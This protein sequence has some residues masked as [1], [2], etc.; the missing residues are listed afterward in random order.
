MSI[1]AGMIWVVDKEN[2]EIGVEELIGSTEDLVDSIGDIQTM[3]LTEGVLEG[4]EG[5]IKMVGGMVE[6]E[7]RCHLLDEE[8][9]GC[10]VL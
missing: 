7:V 9:H 5:V 4:G 2:L 1:M 10:Q 8:E 6:V 3:V